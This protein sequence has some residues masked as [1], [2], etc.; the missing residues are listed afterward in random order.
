VDWKA[1]FLLFCS[2]PETTYKSEYPL[3]LGAR[4]PP[5]RFQTLAFVGE[6]SADLGHTLDLH[7]E[8]ILGIG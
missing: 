1:T 3:G 6:T 4:M 8:E 7:L 2:L 5:M